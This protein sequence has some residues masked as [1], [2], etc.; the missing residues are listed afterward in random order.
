[1]QCHRISDRF[2][3][4]DFDITILEE[5][6]S[7]KYIEDREEYYIKK[8]DSFENGLNETLEGK[9]HNHGSEK[10]T[11]LGYKFSDEQRRN[12]SIAA[13]ERAEREGHKKRSDMVKRAW[14]KE[15]VREHHSNVRK[16]KRLHPPK[17]SD[18][19]VDQIRKRFLN[20]QPD[21]NKITKQINE[22][23]KNKNSSWKLTNDVVVFSKQYAEEYGVCYKTLVYILNGKNRTEKLECLYK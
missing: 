19:Q 3:N 11:T 4:D 18:E 22:Y 21:I 17:L 10:F 13:K 20:E 8:Y 15:G 7:R 2:L 23:R 1:M 14:N 16:G 9:G 6:E 12:M 5:S